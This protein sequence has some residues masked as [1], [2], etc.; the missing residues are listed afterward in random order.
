MRPPSAP[1]ACGA[2]IT[3]SPRHVRVALAKPVWLPGVLTLTAGLW[4][5][6]TVAG[7]LL[8]PPGQIVP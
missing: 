8:W 3:P 7:H 6:A 2:L 5:A 1:G 4:L